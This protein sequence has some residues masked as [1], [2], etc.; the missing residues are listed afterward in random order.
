MVMSQVTSHASVLRGASLLAGV[1]RRYVDLFLISF[2]GLFLELACIR[3]FGSTVV[4]LT[5]FTNFV[6]MACFLGLS[7]GC[8][9]ADK[10]KDYIELV[11]PLLMVTAA[12]AFSLLWSYYKF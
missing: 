11:L 2:L 8:L 4:F 9:T 7:V 6:L 1:R 12:L 5:F 10:R 3:W